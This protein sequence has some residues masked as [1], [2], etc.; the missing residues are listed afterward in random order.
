MISGSILETS[1]TLESLRSTPEANRI[2]WRVME[3]RKNSPPFSSSL[4]FL[5]NSSLWSRGRR[6]PARPPP[7]WRGALNYRRS[8]LPPPGHKCF[9]CLALLNYCIAL[10]VQSAPTAASLEHTNKKEQTKE[11][12]RGLHVGRNLAKDI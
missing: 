5:F 8:L 4:C 3:R 6:T 7:L 9:T 10:Y 12:R 1:A 2:S 11:A